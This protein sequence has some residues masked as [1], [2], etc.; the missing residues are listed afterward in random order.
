VID[1]AADPV[2]RQLRRLEMLAPD[3]RRAEQI[4]ER[5][6]GRLRR[7][8]PASRLGPALVTGLCVLYLFAI[9]IDVLRLRGVI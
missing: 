7:P 1:D 2:V 3:Q 5:C 6:R 9:V 4:R 8:P